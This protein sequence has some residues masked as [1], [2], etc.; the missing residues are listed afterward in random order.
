MAELCNITLHGIFQASIVVG[1]C[2][3]ML[4]DAMMQFGIQVRVHAW[5]SP[6]KNDT[7]SS[8]ASKDFT[9]LFN[10]YPSNN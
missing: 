8:G 9:V 7:S 4:E 5:V 1:H 2:L 10:V 3:L 6:K